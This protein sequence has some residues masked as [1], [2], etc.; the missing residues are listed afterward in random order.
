MATWSS[1]GLRSVAPLPAQAASANMHSTIEVR[2][3]GFMAAQRV[4]EERAVALTMASGG[5]RPSAGSVHWS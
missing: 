4:G 1:V 5:E 3:V 2:I